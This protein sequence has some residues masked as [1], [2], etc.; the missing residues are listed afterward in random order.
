MFWNTSDSGIGKFDSAA[1]LD[2][3]IDAAHPLIGWENE[4]KIT[5]FRL[6]GRIAGINR[7]FAGALRQL[8]FGRQAVSN[9]FVLKPA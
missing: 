3:Y 9:P 2:K 7:T 5:H 6:V 1:S 8:R 4:T